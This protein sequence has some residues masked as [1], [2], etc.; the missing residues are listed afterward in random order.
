MTRAS[1]RHHWPLLRALMILFAAICTI[2]SILNLIRDPDNLLRLRNDG[3]DWAPASSLYEPAPPESGWRSDSPM[4][5]RSESAEAPYYWLRIP[6]KEDNWNDPYLMINNVSSVRVWASGE[7]T[8]EYDLKKRRDRINMG[9]HWNLAKIPEPLPSDAYLLL[10]TPRQDLLPWIMIGNRADLL[11]FMIRRDTDNLL[12]AALLLFCGLV[13]IGVFAV[14]REK[15]YLYF[16]LLCF[17][18]GGSSLI[19]NFTLKILWDY[20]WLSYFQTVGLMFGVAA[21]MGVVEALFPR[22]CGRSARILKRV[23][24]GL[25][26]V[27]LG[28]SLVSL[29]GYNALTFVFYPLFFLVIV[30]LF[31]TVWRAYRNGRDVESAWMLAGFSTM[32]GVACVHVLHFMQVPFL[33]DWLRMLVPALKRMP[34][35]LIFW[36]LLLNVFC[37]VRVIVH[38]FGRMNRQLAEFNRDLELLVAE[39]TAELRQSSTEL[40]AAN[41]KLSSSMKETAEAMAETM[42]LEERRRITG[43]IH[44]T[45]GH[46]LTATLVQL[47]A[48][49]RLIGRDDALSMEKMNASQQLVSKGL[50]EIRLSALL[51]NGSSTFDLSTAMQ[52]LI[53]DTKNLTG[54]SIES[55]IGELPGDLS[56]VHKR[57]LYQALQE[58]LTNG[59]RHGEG[60]R[61]EFTLSADEKGIRFR[62]ANDGRTYSPSEFGFGLKAM[63][64]RVAQLGGRMKVEPG[65][66]GCILELTLPA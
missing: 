66:P 11:E 38:R 48:A 37:I 47:E 28:V 49:K 44:D 25:S 5:S 58:G 61:F 41:E 33:S 53:R 65:E 8:Y 36:G 13:S 26:S 22:A 46:V 62:L 7:W 17:I 27:T 15:L 59:I 9:Y 50:D 64:E 20:R 54:I 30:S 4:P 60:K 19:R 16:F 2:S 52:E 3:W 63:A 35:D 57:V 43:A 51:Q 14:R 18:G 6:L 10:K 24:L 21:F 55:R 40:E 42:V 39:R 23:M 34:T 31:H 29:N 12:I 45:V 1:W 32:T 56:T